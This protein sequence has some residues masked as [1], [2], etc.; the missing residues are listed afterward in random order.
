MA[1]VTAEC[2]P[3]ILHSDHELNAQIPFNVQAAAATENGFLPVAQPQV[4]SGR[5][6]GSAFGALGERTH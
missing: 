3:S 1:S 4:A 2:S 5:T 6:M